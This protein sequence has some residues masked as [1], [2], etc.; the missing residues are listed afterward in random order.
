MALDW[1]SPERPRLGKCWYCGEDNPDHKGFDCLK[2]P[3][4]RRCFYCGEE[5]P[6]HKGSDCE[7]RFCRPCKRAKLAAQ[8]ED[9]RSKASETST[10]VPPYDDEVDQVPPPRYVGPKTGDAEASQPKPG[11]NASSNA[12]VGAVVPGAPS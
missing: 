11:G 8:R 7:K 3:R 2:R 12:S 6:D 5:N 4:F 1:D 9:M 10:A